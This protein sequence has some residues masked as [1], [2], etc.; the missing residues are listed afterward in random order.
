MQQVYAPQPSNYVPQ[1][2]AI[3]PQPQKN[4]RILWIVLA[5][6]F[7]GMILSMLG[8]WAYWSFSKPQ[9]EVVLSDTTVL[10][11]DTV[12]QTIPQAQPVAPARPTM[13]LRNG[14]QYNY[15]GTIAGQQVSVV[16]NNSG[17]S[18][19]GS[20]RYTKFTNDNQLV[21]IGTINGSDLELYEVDEVGNYTGYIFAT[22]TANGISGKF[23]NMDSGKR[24]KVNLIQQ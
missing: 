18:V 21:L 8:I 15:S 20:Y 5:T 14:G 2:P 9:T 23:T 4:L 19:S 22:L 11:T 10:V 16:L 17:G 1:Q 7:I 12:Y 24:Y 6:L 13:T 3:T